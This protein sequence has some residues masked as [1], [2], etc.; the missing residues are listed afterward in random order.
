MATQKLVTLVV[1]A[2]LAALAFLKPN[3]KVGNAGKWILISIPFVHLVE[4][5]F[6][7]KVLQQAEGSLF[8]HFVQTFMFGY[9]H[10]APL[11]QT[12]P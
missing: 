4:F 9:A 11:Y 5:A 10:W 7:Y 8:G 1:Y 3:S 2:V 12:L 6:V